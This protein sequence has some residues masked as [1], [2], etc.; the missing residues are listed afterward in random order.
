M[1]LDEE[2]VAEITGGA[3]LNAAN[4]DAFAVLVRL[5]CDHLGE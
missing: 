2:A 3:D 4:P 5:R 1:A